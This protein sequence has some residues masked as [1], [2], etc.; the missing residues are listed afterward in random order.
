MYYE[1]YE[2]KRGRKRRRRRGGCLGRLIGLLLKLLALALAVCAGLYFL[3]TSLMMVEKSEGLSPTDG[4]PGSPYNLL[5][6]GVDT[7]SEGAQRSDTM[8]IASVSGGGVKLTSL[9]RD[10]MVS[11]PGYGQAKL[12]AAFAYGG[13][14]LTLRVVNETFGMN[15]VR[16]VVVDFTALVKMVDALGGVEVDVTEAERE[17]INKNVRY[18]GRVFAPLGYTYEE[19]TVCGG[20]THLSGLQ[21]LGYARIRKIDSDF[22]R[23]S[24]QRTVISAMLDALKARPWRL[25]SF[26][27]AAL[28]GIDTNLSAVELVS[29]G[30]KAIVGG[31]DGALRLPVD[32][33]FTDDGSRL[34]MTDAQ[35]NIDALYEFLYGDT[36][37]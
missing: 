2:K 36:E 25:V 18:S 21:A 27:R 26:A 5:V 8:M 22:V 33:S 37:K 16:Y 13:P 23:T 1:P 30:E 35:R 7:L 19:L 31:V 14:E 4:L 34:T 6:L 32:G 12:N 10:L 3:P 11:I 15:L 29:L 24:R 20:N 28:Q 9:Q 17:Q